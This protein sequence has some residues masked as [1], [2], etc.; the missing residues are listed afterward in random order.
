[1]TDRCLSLRQRHCSGR[2]TC[3]PDISPLVRPHLALSRPGCLCA[4]MNG[5]VDRPGDPAHRR[6]TRGG[7][8]GEISAT[9]RTA[10]CWPV[11][12]REGALVVGIVP[13]PTTRTRPDPTRPDKVRRLVRDPREHDGLCRGSRSQT[14]V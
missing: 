13:H 11:L 5:S 3:R 4:T 12:T 7:C 1:M 10:L 2:L 6:R 9:D 8:I 14:R